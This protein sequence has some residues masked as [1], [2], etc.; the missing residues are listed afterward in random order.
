MRNV[1]PGVKSLIEARSFL[2]QWLESVLNSEMI[3]EGNLSV[4]A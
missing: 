3:V 2:Q 1:N 4:E